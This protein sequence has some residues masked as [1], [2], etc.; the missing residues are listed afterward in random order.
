VD[1][2]RT[3]RKILFA[4]VWLTI[5]TGMV[6]LLAASIGKKNKERCSDFRIAVK[7]SQD[8]FF[9]EDK[10]VFQLLTTATHG[11]IKGQPMSTVDLHR[12]EGV[13]E[14]N[15]W[16]K[17][18]QLYFDNNDVLH[19]TVTEREPIARIFTTAN[20][21]FYIDNTLKKLPLSDKVT[22]KVPVF[23]DY[24]EKIAAVKDSVLLS[25]VKNIAGFVLNNSFWMSQVAQIDMDNDHEFEM[26]PVLGNHTVD[27]GDG[28]DIE[29]KFGRLMIFYKDVLSKT[30]FDKY[31]SIDVRFAG[32][33]VA[34]KGKAMT[35]IDSVQLRKNVEKLLVQAQQM[36][37]DTSFTTNQTIEKPIMTKD[38]MEEN[39]ERPEITN[40]KNPDHA[41]VKSS[42]KSKP[43]EKPKKPKAVMPKKN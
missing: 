9:I 32:Q 39:D 41:P 16:I 27:L 13:L 11:K 24:P 2:K 30:G 34:V 4:T 23:T 21:S 17:E 6:I 1:T 26:I 12:L 33:V 8:H 25:Q 42:L 14:N 37:S 20:K 29:K 43:D 15:V 22:A 31:A 38:I 7:G 5:G 18:A 36:Q 10:D 40:N 19:V 28:N 35:K 3:I